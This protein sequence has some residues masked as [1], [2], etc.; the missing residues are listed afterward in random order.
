MFDSVL[1]FFFAGISFWNTKTQIPAIASEVYKH[2]KPSAY[3]LI[4]EDYGLYD[5]NMFD[6]KLLNLFGNDDVFNSYHSA[7]N[8]EIGED[9]AEKNVEEGKLL[10]DIK[11]LLNT[12]FEALKGELKN[13]TGDSKKV[14]EFQ[15]LFR[16]IVWYSTTPNCYSACVFCGRYLGCYNCI[17]RLDSCPV[18]RKSFK[19]SCSKTLPCNLMFI[20]GIEDLLE[21]PS[22]RRNEVRENSRNDNDSLPSADTIPMALPEE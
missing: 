16:C 20:P 3:N 8:V 19:C 17:C 4:K 7:K 22:I 15:S 6:D 2:Y 18:C 14:L 12:K 1:L 5:E 13:S 9:L 11:N 21:I 10:N